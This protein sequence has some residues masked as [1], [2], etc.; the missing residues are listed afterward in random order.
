MTQFSGQL[1]V[2]VL[3]QRPGKLSRTYVKYFDNTELQR[4]LLW[5][6]QKNRSSVR[7]HGA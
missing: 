7:G 6:D 2:S 4:L 3:V 5:C 1:L